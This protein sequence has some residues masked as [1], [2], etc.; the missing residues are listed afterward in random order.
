MFTEH[1]K[2]VVRY[3]Y[4]QACATEFVSITF[5]EQPASMNFRA[6]NIAIIGLVGRAQPC[7]P[8]TWLS[9]NVPYSLESS[10]KHQNMVRRT[11][12]NDMIFVP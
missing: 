2:C 12:D 7:S 11:V 1:F 4:R 5:G 9:K 10:R 6:G 8:Q 3:W